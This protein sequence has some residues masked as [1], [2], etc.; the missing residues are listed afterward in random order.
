[1][2]KEEEVCGEAPHKRRKSEPHEACRCRV[3]RI[4]DYG[5]WIVD[6]SMTRYWLAFTLT[7]QLLCHSFL[8][9][10]H[11]ASSRSDNGSTN[12]VECVKIILQILIKDV[13]QIES[14][15]RVE[16]KTIS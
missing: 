2:R 12:I 15:K 4:T 16:Y 5:E 8:D 3:T 1:M 10:T 6:I 14:G 13:L 7:D 11:C 9:L